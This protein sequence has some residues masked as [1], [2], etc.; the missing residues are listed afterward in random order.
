M[1]LS[2]DDKL[3]CDVGLGNRSDEIELDRFSSDRVDFM[4][5]IS[6]AISL[7]LLDRLLC[8]VALGCSNVSRAG[9]EEGRFLSSDSILA[10]I[11]SMGVRL[12]LS[13]LSTFVKFFSS[14]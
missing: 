11:T 1:V 10:Q 8:D 9:V 4:C 3:V 2:L 5:R 13:A 12:T 6:D 7:K 14:L